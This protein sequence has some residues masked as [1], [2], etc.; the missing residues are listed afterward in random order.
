MLVDCHGGAGFDDVDVKVEEAGV[1][2]GRGWGSGGGMG[3]I[4]E[5]FGGG[6][7]QVAPDVEGGD[8]LVEVVAGLRVNGDVG[9]EGRGSDPDCTVGCAVVGEEVVTVG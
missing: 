6:R 8:D 2:E 7:T 1:A 9:E 4:A 5:V 3:V